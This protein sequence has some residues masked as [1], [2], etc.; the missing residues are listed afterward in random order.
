MD[1]DF[2]NLVLLPIGLGLFGFIEPCSIG[3]TLVFI[4]A[5]EGKSTVVKF[6][7][8]SVFALTR[9]LFIGLLGLLAA[10]IGSAFLGFQKKRVDT[11]GARLRRD[12]RHVRDRAWSQYHAFYRARALAGFRASAAQPAL[13]CCS[14]STFRPAPPLCSS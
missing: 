10:T 7:Q 4:K 12:W 1:A 8:V 6:G 5:M 2:F 3:S 14:A 9:G 11:A 13:A